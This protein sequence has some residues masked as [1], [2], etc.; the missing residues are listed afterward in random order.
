MVLLADF[1]G[2]E[3]RQ[4]QALDDLQ[5]EAT[6][7]TLKFRL[8][9]ALFPSRYYVWAGDYM[10]SLDLWDVPIRQEHRHYLWLIFQGLHYQWKEL[11]RIAKFEAYINDCIQAHTDQDTPVKHLQFTQRLLQQQGWLVNIV[12]SETT[13]TQYLQ[14]IAALFKTE[15]GNMLNTPGQMV[16]DTVF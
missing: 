3:E 8:I 11:T 15:L 12:K 7:G 16:K 6:R 14:F 4:R 10:V 1:P 2:P 5:D 13:P 9:F